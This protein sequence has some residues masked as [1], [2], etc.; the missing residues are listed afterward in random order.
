MSIEKVAKLAGVSNS[1]VSRVIND[2]PRVAPET[3]RAVEEAMQ[4]LSYTPSDRRPG[5]KPAS[6]RQS[7]TQ[8]GFFM[9]G[10][11][12][13]SATPG[14]TDLLRG[15]SGGASDSDLNLTFAHVPDPD[16]LPGR[17]S[18]Q[19]FDGV[20]LHGSP[21]TGDAL[22]RLKNKPVVWLMGNRKRPAWGD[23]VMPDTLAIGEIAANYLL[24]RGHERLAYLNLDEHHWALRAYGTIFAGTALATDHSVEILSNDRPETQAYWQPYSPE[25]VGEL[26]ERFLDLPTRPTGL[27]VA[28]SMQ[29]AILQPALAQRGVKFGPGKTEIITCNNEEP[30]LLGL[31]PRPAAIDIRIEAIGRRGVD[32][33]AWRIK[34]P[35]TPERLTVSIEPKLVVGNPS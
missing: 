6:R 17:L 13:G 32:Q 18:E 30:Y 16:S 33:L 25:S 29:A 28:D 8:I 31:S 1:T 4:K 23:Q 34:H 35:G 3:K 27:F 21:L 22:S 5:P 14:F 20:L 10:S 26:I 24:D 2:H 19:H 11:R 12:D 15:V 9:V 7:A